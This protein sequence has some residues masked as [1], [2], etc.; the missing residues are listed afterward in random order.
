[1]KTTLFPTYTTATHQQAFLTE[2]AVNKQGM[3]QFCRGRDQKR[4]LIPGIAGLSGVYSGQPSP[5]T[6]QESTRQWGTAVACPA[7]C[8]HSYCRH[9]KQAPGEVMENEDRHPVQTLVPHR[10]KYILK[11]C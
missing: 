8:E 4:F 10:T 1:M 7:R 11:L 6:E 9:A 3:Q 5:G 2:Q